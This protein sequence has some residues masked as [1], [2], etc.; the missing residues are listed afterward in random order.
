MRFIKPH[1][2]ECWQTHQGHCVWQRGGEG[3][4]LQSRSKE[5]QRKSVLLE[6]RGCDCQERDLRLVSGGDWREEGRVEF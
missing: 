3:N 6:R 5:F 2:V 1:D 4:A